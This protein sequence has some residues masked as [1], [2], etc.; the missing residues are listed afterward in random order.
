MISHANAVLSNQQVTV[1]TL[2]LF[3][4]FSLGDISKELNLPLSTVR[5]IKNKAIYLLRKENNETE[6][7]KAFSI[8]YTKND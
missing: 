2:Y 5:S 6:F 3:K 8:L 7:K 4:N 1:L